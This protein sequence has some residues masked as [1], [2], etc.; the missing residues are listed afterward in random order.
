MQRPYINLVTA[1][2][3]DLTTVVPQNNLVKTLPKK[4]GMQFCLSY[5]W[6]AASLYHTEMA[7]L[8][9]RYQNPCRPPISVVWLSNIHGTTLKSESLLVS[10]CE[11][12]IQKYLEWGLR[13]CRVG[14]V[15]LVPA[16][17]ISPFWSVVTIVHLW[18]LRVVFNH[19]FQLLY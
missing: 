3:A 8:H 12:N 13:L 2:S 14:L 7:Y 5:A 9:M 1:A 15:I 4:S 17:Q 6:T 19:I 10:Y 11:Q 16:W 18:Q